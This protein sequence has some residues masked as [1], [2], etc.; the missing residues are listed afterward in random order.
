MPAKEKSNKRVEFPAKLTVKE[1]SL[2]KNCETITRTYKLITPMFGGGFEAAKYDPITPIRASSI[3]GQLRFWWRA[4]CG[5]QF[6]GSLKRLR[7]AE[8]W[9]WG[10]AADDK[11][12]KKKADKQLGESR[13]RISVEVNNNNQ[14]VYFKKKN[15]TW[16]EDEKYKYLKYH[17]YGTFPLRT[18]SNNRL[19]HYKEFT[20]KISFPVLPLYPERE[21]IDNKKHNIEDEVK[22]TLWAWEMFGGIGARTRR[23]FG[24]IQ[25][26]NNE[27]KSPASNNQDEIIA[28][29][30]T[31]L[32][33]HL[34]NGTWPEGIP[35]LSEDLNN[36]HVVTTNKL[37]LRLSP[38]NHN[39]AKI[40][41]NVDVGPWYILL[42]NLSLF[43]QLR[44]GFR[45]FNSRSRWPEPDEIRYI[46]KF[47]D[48][49]HSSPILI[50]KDR[51]RVKKFPRAEFGL[52]IV[53]KFKDGARN[54][55]NYKSQDPYI[56]TLLGLEHERLASPL[57]LKPIAF[58]NKKTIGIAVYLQT[59]GKILPLEK[60]G[61]EIKD[62]SKKVK[63]EYQLDDQDT[64]AIKNASNVISP[65]RFDHN[66][67]HSSKSLIKEFLDFL[68]RNP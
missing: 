9:L 4:T 1:K 34:Y 39:D 65:S 56:T 33:N 17:E 32:E 51:Q 43:R 15:T 18:N 55:N 68:R 50:R 44:K 61:L 12:G 54:S 5:G 11:E 28:W 16:V 57:I 62:G 30:K 29:L 13:I 2:R 48:S 21:V 60:L 14:T 25:S 49:R 8:A 36:Y 38:A 22:A 46:T 7:K 20:I 66:S 67:F 42:N 19:L 59:E 47:S 24:S 26:L 53:F 31:G 41:H 37:N 64:E 40:T 10:A 45:G 3:K 52:P 23:G 27:Y 58:A 63:V 35:H 6:D